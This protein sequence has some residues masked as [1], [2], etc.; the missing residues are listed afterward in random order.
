[1]ADPVFFPA[2]TY[3]QVF[4]PLLIPAEILLASESWFRRNTLRRDLT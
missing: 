1:M 2:A 4:F 3:V